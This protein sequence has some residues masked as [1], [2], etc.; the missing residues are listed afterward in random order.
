MCAGGTAPAKREP[1]DRDKWGA[2]TGGGAR[3][4]THTHVTERVVDDVC[5]VTPTS[6]EEG[7]RSNSTRRAEPLLQ[8]R[9]LLCRHTPEAC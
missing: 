4:H 9:R 1:A 7:G 5:K 8:P 3:G 2:V 6:H